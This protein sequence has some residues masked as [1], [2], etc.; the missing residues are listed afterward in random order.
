MK[1]NKMDFKF[2]FE[3]GQVASYYDS[4]SRKIK[5]G[6]IYRRLYGEYCNF[7]DDGE[8]ERVETY[9]KYWIDGEWRDKVFSIENITKDELLRLIK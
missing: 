8:I 1:I 4:H 3:M 2:Q 6:T 5:S 7:G 9:F